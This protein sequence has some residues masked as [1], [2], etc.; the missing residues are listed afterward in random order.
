MGRLDLDVSHVSVIDVRDM[1][2]H[3]QA[4]MQ[5]RRI[6]GTA[7]A[8]VEKVGVIDVKDSVIDVGGGGPLEGNSWRRAFGQV[9]VSGSIDLEKLQ[10][11]LPKGLLPIG[12]MA[13]RLI[14]QGMTERDS[15]SDFTPA[16]L[17]SAT[18]NGLS[19]VG[20]CPP[21]P[22][23]GPAPPPCTPWRLRGIDLQLDSDIDGESGF[24]EGALRASDD[25]G[26]LVAI[27]AKSQDVPYA[28]LLVSSYP[29]RDLLE[30]TEFVA[31]AVFP[32]RSLGA[33]PEIVPKVGMLGDVEAT[34][35]VSGNVLVPRVSLAAKGVGLR[36][37]DAPA[38]VAMTAAVSAE[39][40][41]TEGTVALSLQTAKERVLTE[42]VKA[43]A[44]FVNLLHGLPVPWSASTKAHATR[45]PLAAFPELQDNNIRGHVSG[46]LSVQDLH[47]DASAEVDLTAVD[48][49]VGPEVYKGGRV[50]ASLKGRTLSVKARVDQPVG[51][52]EVTARGTV[53]WGAAVVPALD[54]G[55]PLFASVDARGFLVRALRPAAGTALSE[56]DGRLDGQASIEAVAKTSSL[57]MEGQL[58]LDDGLVQLTSTGQEFHKVHATLSLLPGGLV[59]LD[60]VSALGLAG[61]WMASGVARMNGLH[62]GEA[63]LDLRIPKG[64]AIPLNVD[65]A[66]MGDV[67]GEVSIVAKSPKP[68]VVAV[69][70]TVPRLH[71]S[72]P[73]ATR[74]NVESLDAAPGVRV[75]VY[76]GDQPKALDFEPPKE[77][78]ELGSA[79]SELDVNI[80]LGNDVEVRRGRSCGSRSG[81]WS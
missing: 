74:H 63:R 6:T 7:R 65:G 19:V 42:E 48:L 17:L 36:A 77:V 66:E 61:K 31:S 8:A 21:R 29:V 47:R 79:G 24:F 28:S 15:E 75:G 80:H 52:V 2:A 81:C 38:A 62:L 33:L 49:R 58:V 69:D 16:L 37:P 4:K 32:R 60:D 71:V 3:V 68:Q 73:V 30:Q 25:K 54:E 39:Y 10:E 44:P 18:T 56:L 53:D 20:S 5:G 70:V 35:D 64:H 51:G 40:D 72:L 43:I 13:G 50:Q 12:K 26:V 78:A 9:N 57:K 27:D 1:S 67:D 34:V 14:F 76:Q 55:Q 11:L 22:L 45:F 41:G 23:F 59:R 46:D